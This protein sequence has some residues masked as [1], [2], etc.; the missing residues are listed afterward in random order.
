MN[1]ME[2]TGDSSILLPLF[3][4]D[5]PVLQK[6]HVLVADSIKFFLTKGWVFVAFG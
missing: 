6:I 4:M 1:S 3:V 2:P 5:M